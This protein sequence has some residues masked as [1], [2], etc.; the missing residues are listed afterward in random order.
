MKCTCGYEYR[1]SSSIMVSLVSLVYNRSNYATSVNI[2]AST[3][4]P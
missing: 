4:I 2:E 3:H 1:S